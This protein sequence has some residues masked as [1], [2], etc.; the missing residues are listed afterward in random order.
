MLRNAAKGSWTLEELGWI[1]YPAGSLTEWD[2]LT[3]LFVGFVQ[4][5]NSV[6]KDAYLRRWYNAAVRN[7]DNAE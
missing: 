4:A 3:S 2:G 6:L 5:G 1:V 7:G